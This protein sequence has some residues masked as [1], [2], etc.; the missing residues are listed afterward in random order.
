MTIDCTKYC[1]K[2]PDLI[3]L[4]SRGLNASAL[5]LLKVVQLWELRANSLK[6]FIWT[7]PI[8]RPTPS[9]STL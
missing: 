9:L 4:K 7:V 5:S 2:Y 8:E 3:L 1:K 6:H